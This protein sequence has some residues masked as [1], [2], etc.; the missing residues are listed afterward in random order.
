[1]AVLTSCTAGSGGAP[2]EPDASAPTFAPDD[3]CDRPAPAAWDDVGTVHTIVPQPDAE[4]V[5]VDMTVTPESVCPGGRVVVEI[6]LTNTSTEPI[7]F[8]PVR[9]LLLMSGGMSNWEL[10]AM[11]PVQLPAGG[12]AT[13]QVQ[14]TVPD[15]RPGVYGLRPEG[16]AGTSL[17]VLA[18][19]ESTAST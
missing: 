14:A 13:V 10:A 18:P 3:G 5:E 15:V 16:Y 19:E 8:R 17:E 6:T 1:M 12:T 7:E 4:H 9:G 11:D 2:V